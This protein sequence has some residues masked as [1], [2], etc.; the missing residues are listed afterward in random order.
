MNLDIGSYESMFLWD[1]NN[2]WPCTSEAV[3][4]SVLCAFVVFVSMSEGGWDIRIKECS[5][6]IHTRVVLERLGKLLED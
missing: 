2:N 6:D 3:W 4:C 5:S 1:K